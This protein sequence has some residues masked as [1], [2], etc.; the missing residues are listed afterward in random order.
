MQTL[1]STGPAVVEEVTGKKEVDI[2][3]LKLSKLLKFMTS[4]K[5]NWGTVKIP[6][7]LKQ[8]YALESKLFLMDAQILVHYIVS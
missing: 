3:R 8:N 4:Q 1:V 7:F 5:G 6:L 2:S